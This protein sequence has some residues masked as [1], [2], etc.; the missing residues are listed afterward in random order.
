MSLK[1]KCVALLIEDDYQEMEAWYPFY[2]LTE[3]GATVTVIGPGH[4]KVFTS[5]LGYEMEATL[6]I[7]D[8][9]IADFDA[10]VVPGGFA[11]DHMRLCPPM[12]DFVRDMDQAGKLVSAICHGGWI[13]ASA[14]VCKGRKI[15]GYA[16]IKDDVVNAGG[17]WVSDQEAVVDGNVITARTPPDLP[18]F[19]AA[20]VAYLGGNA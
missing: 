17:T 2:R 5:K 11:P 14:G 4:K 6:D 3:A 1:D 8:A 20:L 9:R 10:V 19:A 15:T 18:A 7:A 16:P 13:L 12:I